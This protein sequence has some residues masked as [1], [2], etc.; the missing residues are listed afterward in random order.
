MPVRKPTLQ[1]WFLAHQLKKLGRDHFYV[2][3]DL[4]ADITR[5]E[6]AYKAQGKPT[7]Y[8]AIVVKALAL[9]ALRR[10]EIN[11][12]YLPTIFGPRVVEFDHISVNMPV[13]LNPDG[14]RHLGAVTVRDAHRLSIAEIRAAIR[15][16]KA[17]KP[18]D[19]PV[20]RFVHGRKNNLWNRTR[21]R[22]IHFAVYNFP[23]LLARES[24]GLAVSSLISEAGEDCPTRP[25]AFGPTAFTACMSRVDRGNPG[26]T[27][28]HLGIGIDHSAC[29]GDQA[30]AGV[31]ALGEI[32]SAKDDKD[33]AALT[34]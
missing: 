9:A 18:E 3:F 5:V 6:E 11:R 7:P 33:L 23:A 8:T 10:P 19:M 2:P 27:I 30:A 31:K 24:G 22:A 28:L 21:L 34:K 32:L 26:K 1:E 14:E 16:A 25:T 29:R 17:K 20:G 15:A 12:M 4:D 13:I